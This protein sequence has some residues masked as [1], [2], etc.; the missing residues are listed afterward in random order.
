MTHGD[1]RILIF[2]FLLPPL[3]SLEPG[4]GLSVLRMLVKMTMC[5]VCMMKVI[6]IMLLDVY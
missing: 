3:L 1:P 6:T 4:V 5:M 2:F